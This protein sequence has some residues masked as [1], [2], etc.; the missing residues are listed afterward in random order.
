MEN[1]CCLENYFVDVNVVCF[2]S[3]FLADVLNGVRI[4]VSTF[5]FLAKLFC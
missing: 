2:I 3:I 5:L 1:V 4:S